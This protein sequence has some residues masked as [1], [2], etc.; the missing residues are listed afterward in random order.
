MEEQAERKKG[1]DSCRY[2]EERVPDLQP[3]STENHWPHSI[4][5]EIQAGFPLKLPGGEEGAERREAATA[6]AGTSEE[7]VAQG[8][9]PLDFQV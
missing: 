3:F 7:S 6:T 5:R 2:S 8:L 9:L 4:L 1:R